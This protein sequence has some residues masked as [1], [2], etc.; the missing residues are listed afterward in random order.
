MMNDPVPL[1]GHV[2]TVSTAGYWF[3][4][5]ECNFFFKQ[6][7]F[8]IDFNTK[9]K[10]TQNQTKN[11]IRKILSPQKK[12]QTQKQKKIEMHLPH[13]TTIGLHLQFK[14]ISVTDYIY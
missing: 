10:K 3:W 8:N 9:G 5:P 13:I 6:H 11:K 4:T 12:P 7:S 1:P 14:N 2:Q